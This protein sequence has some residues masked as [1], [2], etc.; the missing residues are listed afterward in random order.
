[1]LNEEFLI[2]AS[3]LRKSV[4]EIPS[5]RSS[6]SE[7]LQPS[8]CKFYLEHSEGDLCWRQSESDGRKGRVEY[9]LRRGDG[10]GNKRK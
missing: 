9:H 3:Y 1:V 10:L 6:V 4:S 2:L 8:R 5:W 7:D